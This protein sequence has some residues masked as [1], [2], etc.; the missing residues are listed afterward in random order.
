MIVKTATAFLLALVFQLAQLGGAVDFRQ[1]C[2][3]SS[4]AHCGCCAGADSCHCADNN[5]SAP[6]PAPLLPASGN[7][8]KLPL[9]RSGETRVSLVS[10]H[11]PA[12]RTAAIERP[13]ERPF[14]GYNGVSLAVAFCS[15]VI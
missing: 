2:A 10:R 5:E 13:A 9:A 7:D 1:E 11:I 3:M 4:A 14:A 15:F 6:R 12:A 8:L